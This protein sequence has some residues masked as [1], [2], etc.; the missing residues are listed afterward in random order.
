MKI[1]LNTASNFVK[2]KYGFQDWFGHAVVRSSN[3]I[4]DVMLRNIHKFFILIVLRSHHRL[5]VQNFNYFV[6]LKFSQ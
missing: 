4:W 5:R 2:E 6:C 3:F 1:C